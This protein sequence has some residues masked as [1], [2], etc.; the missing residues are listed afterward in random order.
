VNIIINNFFTP[1]VVASRGIANLITQTV[2][3]FSQNFYGALDPQIT[4]NYAVG[5]N[6]NM[7]KLVFSGTKIIF[8][9]MYLIGLPL[10]L[11]LPYVV[12][13]WLKNPP[14]YTVVFT[15]LGLIETLVYSLSFT[16]ISTIYAVGKVKLYQLLL[17]GVW[18]FQL[19]L[20]LILLTF[21]F[22]VYSV[23]ISSLL[24]NLILVVIRI[25]LL[26]KLIEYSVKYFMTKVIFPILSASFFASLLPIFLSNIMMQCFL[27]LVIVTLSSIIS[28][29][30][31]MYFIGLN[32]DER[33]MVKNVIINIRYKSF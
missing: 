14:E 32:K 15:R 2:L 6:D 7:F 4:K 19:P 23:I 17:G 18:I 10:F 11:E 30:L 13:L 29:S 1:I 28:V 3:N 5:H 25:L 8:Y 9:L 12:R 22:P 33:R 31:F 20:S 21:G 24:L 26:R 16:I 27:R